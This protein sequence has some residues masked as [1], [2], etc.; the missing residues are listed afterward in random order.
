MYLVQMNLKLFEALYVN[1]NCNALIIHYIEISK[2]F[3]E[4]GDCFFV[5]NTRLIKHKILIAA[6]T[7]DVSKI[8]LQ[9]KFHSV[10]LF[11]FTSR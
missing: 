3:S 8:S 9:P 10:D 1:E 7:H 6:K 11:S 5:A 4:P 2:I